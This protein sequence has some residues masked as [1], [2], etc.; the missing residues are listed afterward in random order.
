MVAVIGAGV[1]GWGISAATSSHS[2]L[3]APT[4][5]PLNS[6]PLL[7]ASG[8]NVGQVFLFKGSK[9]QG[10]Q[11]WMYMSMDLPNGDGTV[12]CQVVDSNGKVTTV[13]SFRLTDGNGAWASAGSWGGATVHTA[14]VLAPD[15]TVL[16][17][18]TFAQ[19]YAG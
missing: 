15:G 8:R 10:G 13:G 16:A 9:D 2:D 1:A 4:Q 7:T 17:T 6:A 19:N 14:R 5:A 11:Q 3:S 12:T 18:A